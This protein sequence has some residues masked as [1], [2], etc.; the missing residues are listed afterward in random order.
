MAGTLDPILQK[1]SFS[2]DD[3]VIPPIKIPVFSPSEVDLTTRLT[4]KIELKIPILSAPM[5]TVTEAKM[6][7]LLA[8]LGGIGVIHNNL[9]I[10]SQVK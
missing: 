1:S 8:C 6:A 9:S 7:I 2:L 3:I 10:E 4:K 5:D